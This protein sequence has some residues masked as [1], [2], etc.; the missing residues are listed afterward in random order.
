M[1]DTRRT[2]GGLRRKGSVKA[3]RRTDSEI[4]VC[5]RSRQDQSEQGVKDADV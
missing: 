1:R 5:L 3:E 2:F 4:G